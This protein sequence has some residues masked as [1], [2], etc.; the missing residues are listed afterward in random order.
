[1]PTAAGTT[2]HLP[3]EQARPP[4][5]GSG[6]DSPTVLVAIRHPAVSRLACEV[7]RHDCGCTRVTE[8]GQDLLKDALQRCRPDLLLIDTG[9][10][11]ACCHHALAAF[12]TDRVIVV[13]PEPARDY[14]DSALSHG[15]GS[16]IA[17][18]YLAEQ[19]PGEV[20]RLSHHP[21]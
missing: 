17:R 14:R 7:L 8:L 16:W 4:T 12:P 19:L 1:M 21:R 13:G 20:H 6:V 11:P 15:A 9:D 18:D 10:F 2:R 5:P 3:A